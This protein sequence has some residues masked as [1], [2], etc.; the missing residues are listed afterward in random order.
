ML[1]IFCSSYNIIHH[2]IASLIIS[3]LFQTVEN[4]NLHYISV[5]PY[6]KGQSDLFWGKLTYSIFTRNR[7][8]IVEKF[9]KINTFY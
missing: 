6:F 8:F 2:V 4:L 5:K 3:H 1:W 7:N 9:I